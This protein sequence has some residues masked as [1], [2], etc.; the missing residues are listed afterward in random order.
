MSSSTS[1][2]VDIF[3]IPPVKPRFAFV[4]YTEPT[5]SIAGVVAALNHKPV[6]VD[7]QFAET[8][9]EHLAIWNGH[10][11]L[12]TVVESDANRLLPLALAKE[13]T[14]LPAYATEYKGTDPYGKRERDTSADIRPLPKRLKS[15]LS[16]TPEDK[17]DANPVAIT[18]S[19]SHPARP[20]SSTLSDSMAIAA[21]SSP[22]D[23]N[24]S[25]NSHPHG[26][27]PTPLTASHPGEPSSAMSSP[28]GKPPLT[29]S[30]AEPQEFPIK[31]S[32][33]TLQAQINL[34][35]NVFVKHDKSN[36]I[37]HTCLIATDLDQAR[38]ALQADLYATD[39][40]FINGRDL[41]GTLSSRGF[42]A[43]R[44]DAFITKV[45]KVL[46]GIA[47]ADEL[48][49]GGPPAALVEDSSSL[50]A[51]LAAALDEYPEQTREAM[52]AAGKVLEYLDRGKNAQEKKR[53]DVE[54][55]VGVLQGMV[56]IGEQVSSVVRYLLTDGQ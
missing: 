17:S 43:P 12:L 5:V 1:N 38:R 52:T 28:S 41:E 9:A 23:A 21:P 29:N 8:H 35:R 56:K 40:A 45:L 15:G 25:Q 36:W 4:T 42:T 55:R 6:K 50:E 37:A 19:D 24:G 48:E 20:A 18:S 46:D 26:L 33:K 22:P 3:S 30:A 14:N 54:R 16:D 2:S 32:G 39:E 47:L 34:V 44:V 53:L 31:L 13:F 11:S 27:P 49:Q 7:P 10:V 51:E